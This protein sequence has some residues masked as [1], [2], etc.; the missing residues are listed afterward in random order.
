[1]TE[2]SALAQDGL[3][4]AAEALEDLPGA[5]HDVR[6][7][8]REHGASQEGVASIFGGGGRVARGE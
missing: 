4:R 2:G 6:H 3:H 8:H 5:A 7:V 1:M